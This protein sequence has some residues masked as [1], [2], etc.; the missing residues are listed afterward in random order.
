MEEVKRIYAFLLKNDGLKI[1]EIAEHL[2]MEKYAIAEILFSEE[3]LSYWFQDD[4]SLWYAKEDALEL[5]EDD[6]E[7]D[8][9]DEDEDEEQS[10]LSLTLEIPRFVNYAKYI[11]N[12]TS[13]ALRITLEDISKY[14]ILTT[15]ETYVYLAKYKNGNKRAR[16]LIVRSNLRFVMNVANLY[17]D[18]GVPLEDLFQEGCIG[19]L[20]AIEKFELG[21]NSSFF[22]YA[23]AW[24]FQAI[25]NAVATLPYMIKIPINALSAHR[26][27]QDKI[28]SF[29]NKNGYYPS[30]E[31]LGIVQN[32]EPMYLFGW[33]VDKKYESLYELYALPNDL[34]DLVTLSDE[35]DEF[36]YPLNDIENYIEKENK[37]T[38]VVGYLDL[39]GKRAREIL[40]MYYG[41]NLKDCESLDNIGIKLGISRERA[42]QIVLASKKIIKERALCKNK[43]D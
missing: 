37:Q 13:L 2:G 3:N 11:E 22:E 31:D 27:M 16:D 33:Y 25:S 34:L 43:C 7:D 9:E 17:K 26:K 1:R 6:D 12:T 24:I 10:E 42:R 21:R 28:E 29:E 8:D 14:R 20:K 39:L 23:K 5:D 38:L 19:L 30:L 32:D 36:E 4:S 41:I 18:K 35:I 15:E 40:E